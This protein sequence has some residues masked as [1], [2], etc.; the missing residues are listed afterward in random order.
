MNA[1]LQQ[2]LNNLNEINLNGGKYICKVCAKQY[3]HQKTCE[4]HIVDEHA[5]RV[6]YQMKIINERIKMNEDAYYHKFLFTETDREMEK[7]KEEITKQKEKMMTDFTYYFDHY[8][9]PILLNEAELLLLFQMKRII[10]SQESL[11]DIYVGLCNFRDELRNEIIDNFPRHSCTN[12]L[13]NITD[14]LKV[15]AKANFVKN[16]FDNGLINKMIR[17][18]DKLTK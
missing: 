3:V 6:D 2:A 7:L 1:I 5:G 14:R 18:A 11:E 9:E 10:E 17:C 8:S 16:R 13:S 4:K 12:E 15:Q